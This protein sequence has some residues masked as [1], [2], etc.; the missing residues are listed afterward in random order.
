MARYVMFYGTYPD[1]QEDETRQLV[2]SFLSLWTKGGGR[3]VARAGS[4]N[5]PERKWPIELGGVKPI[6]DVVVDVVSDLLPKN[7]KLRVETLL[8][9]YANSDRTVPKDIGQNK[10]ELS[11]RRY[12]AYST[13]LSKVDLFVFIG[14]SDGVLRLALICHFTNKK[15]L[16]ISQAGGASKEIFDSFYQASPDMHYQN[17]SHNDCLQLG[18]LQSDGK[19]LHDL[20]EKNLQSRIR[21]LFAELF[22]RR[23]SIL[24]FLQELLSTLENLIG[25]IARILLIL[26]IVAPISLIYKSEIEAIIEDV[27]AL[28]RETL[29]SEDP[30]EPEDG[31]H[32]E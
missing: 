22:S 31:N 8:S 26:S 10:Y 24:D 6:D 3:V 15:F 23:L 28:W 29:P 1:K 4:G 19:K 20:A 5:D 13:L 7:K 16:A 21:F 9:T 11:D 17:L 14:G 27:E 32:G 2:S 25:R 18:S 12:E 30:S